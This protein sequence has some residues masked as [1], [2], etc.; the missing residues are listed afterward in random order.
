M[1]NRIRP[2][3]PDALRER[4]CLAEKDVSLAYVA[5][6]DEALPGLTKPSLLNAGDAVCAA[7]IALLERLPT[8]AELELSRDASV[9]EIVERI[10]GSEEFNAKGLS[11]EE[12][13]LR[14]LLMEGDLELCLQ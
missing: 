2:F 9:E 11:H 13:G 4:G 12:I 14:I 3:P 7:Y 10:L 1:G 5:I 8:E 6:L